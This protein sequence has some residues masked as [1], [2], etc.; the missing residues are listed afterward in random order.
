MTEYSE[1]E[2]FMYY[3]PSRGLHYPQPALATTIMI[4]ILSSSIVTPSNSRGGKSRFRSHIGLLGFLTVI[5]I[6]F[7]SLDESVH[8]RQKMDAHLY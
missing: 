2:H 1:G 7:P 4:V 5:L 6:Q 3:P 8:T